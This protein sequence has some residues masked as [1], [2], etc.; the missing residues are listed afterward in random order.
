VLAPAGTPAAIV[1]KVNADIQKAMALAEV[2]AQLELQ[3][4]QAAGGSPADFDRFIRSEIDK[5]AKAI[6][7]AGVPPA[8]I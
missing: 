5:W 6:K 7:A 1:T 8:D 2:K 3:G 4:L